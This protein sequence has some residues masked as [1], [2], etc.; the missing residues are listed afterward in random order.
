M[1]TG[2]SAAIT[3]LEIVGLLEHIYIYIYVCIY[4]YIW[5]FAINRGPQYKPQFT[6]IS[7]NWYPQE[8]TL[9]FRK[10]PYT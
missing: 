9:D 4:I 2:S 8:G 6:I 5:E 1:N 3:R 10:P 7:L